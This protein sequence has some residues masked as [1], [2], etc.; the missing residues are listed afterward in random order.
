[1]LIQQIRSLAAADEVTVVQDSQDQT[2]QSTQNK[3]DHSYNFKSDDESTSESDVAI[4][5]NDYMANTRSIENL[6]KYPP[7]KRL[8][9]LYST[10]LSSSAP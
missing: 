3:K 9:L 2:V 10:A 5:A 7:V 6:H 8:F 4:E 1:M